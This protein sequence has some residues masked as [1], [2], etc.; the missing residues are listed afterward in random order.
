MKT[1]IRHPYATIEMAGFIPAWLSESSKPIRDQLN[2]G[3]IWGGFRHFSGFSIDPSTDEL[4][5]PG[6]PPT[7]PLIEWQFDSHPQ[8]VILYQHSWVAIIEPDGTF[9]VCRMD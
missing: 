4:L 2:D 3:Y 7:I 6:D 9:E 1:I 8:R 5:Y